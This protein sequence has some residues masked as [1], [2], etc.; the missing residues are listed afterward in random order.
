MARFIK[1]DNGTKILN[2]DHIIKV[3]FTPGPGDEK[4]CVIATDV[5]NPGGKRAEIILK[6][7]HAQEV[8]IQ[9]GYQ[10]SADAIIMS[11]QIK[12]FGELLHQTSVR[13]E[14]AM[15]RLADQLEN[16]SHRLALHSN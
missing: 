15:T 5:M 8:Y 3:D 1:F 14:G 9:L 11:D 13:L 12:D 7:E 2:V 6:G 4:T 10:L 16:V